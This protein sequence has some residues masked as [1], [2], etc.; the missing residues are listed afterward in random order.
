MTKKN[1]IN[2][3]L[4]ALAFWAIPTI[5]LAQST[6][7]PTV[8]H[9]PAFDVPIPANLAAILAA[10]ALLIYWGAKLLVKFLT[11]LEVKYPWL[12]YVDAFIEHS[13]GNKDV[14][15]AKDRVDAPTPN[16]LPTTQPPATNIKQ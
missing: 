15:P 3:T 2:R 1:T 8:F 14:V 7:A 6:N 11:P 13:L 9:V 12:T 5:L 16:G 10:H 4:V